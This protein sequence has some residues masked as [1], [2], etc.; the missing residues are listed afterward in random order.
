MPKPSTYDSVLRKTEHGSKLYEAWKKLRR[1]PHCEEW[2]YYPA[3]YNW[4]IQNGYT[5]GVWLVLIDKSGEYCPENCKWHIPKRMQDDPPPPPTWA[6]EWNKT[7]N[8]I[9]KYYG[10]QP[11]EG[12]EHGD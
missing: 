9:R 3:F 10:M 4:A 8:R 12:T 6:D 2:N 5:L 11:L 7:V 1:S